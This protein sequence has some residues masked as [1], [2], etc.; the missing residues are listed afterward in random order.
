M[1]WMANSKSFGCVGNPHAELVED[2]G[3]LHENLVDGLGNGLQVQIS[4]ASVGVQ[5][6]LLT[7]VALEVSPSIRR[8]RSRQLKGRRGCH[9][10]TRRHEFAC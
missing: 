4:K 7:L 9:Q 2:V 1:P 10:P 8:G 6:A 5:G 3:E